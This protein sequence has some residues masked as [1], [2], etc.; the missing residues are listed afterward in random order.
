MPPNDNGDQS[1]GFQA[2]QQVIFAKGTLLKL[3][4]TIGGTILVGISAV[5]AFYWQHH[6]R[7]TTHMENGSIH[8]RAGERGDLET[9][10]EAQGHRAKLV[11]EVKREVGIRHRELK[12]SQGEEIKQQIKKMGS[13]QKAE[14]KRLLDEVRQTRRAV[15]KSHLK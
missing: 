13:T 1:G 3:A 12:V 9:K 15:T 6:Y 5:L 2:V 14:L 11:K 7:M 4:L 10:A 8:L